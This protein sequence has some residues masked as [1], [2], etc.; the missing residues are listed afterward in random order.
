[1]AATLFSTRDAAIRRGICLEETP[2]GAEGE[3]VYE[4][5]RWYRYNTT[6]SE[7][8]T[9]DAASSDAVLCWGRKGSA[10][11]GEGCCLYKAPNATFFALILYRYPW[12]SAKAIEDLVAVINGI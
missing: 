2:T 6:V 8:T 9:D 11:E 5:H 3:R 4:T 7:G 1:L 10:F 12:V